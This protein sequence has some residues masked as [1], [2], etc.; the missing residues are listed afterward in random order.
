MA[1]NRTSK[2]S[3]EGRP[4]GPAQR[5][6]ALLKQARE[7]AGLS[8]QALSDQTKIQPRLLEALERGDLRDLP[9]PAHGRGFVRNVARACGAAEAQALVLFD[10]SLGALRAAALPQPVP[11]PRAEA[12]PAPA[13]A[14]R[15]QPL[16]DARA[17]F[18]R[19]SAFAALGVLLLLGLLSLAWQRSMAAKPVALAPAPAAEPAVPAPD[20]APGKAERAALLGAKG[21]DELVLRAKKAT[22]ASL[23]VDGQAL[24]LVALAHGEKR[25]FQV[26]ARAVVLLGDASV[27]RVWWRGE[28]LGYL[29]SKPGPLNG[30]VFEH[31]MKWHKDSAQALAQ[32]EGAPAPE[33][34]DD[35][36]TAASDGALGD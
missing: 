20:N 16:A 7:A 36:A 19:L 32:P 3:G 1:R 34:A 12:K 21:A 15:S 30:L 5:L 8:L 24:P 2:K 23:M 6:G 28:N 13:K 26:Q 14:R 31:G 27:V 29:G 10:E 35:S 4:A 9:S 22:W 17:G 11:A 33:A 25:H 18:W